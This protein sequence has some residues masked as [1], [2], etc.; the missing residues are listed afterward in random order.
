M[1]TCGF[2]KVLVLCVL[3]ALL[4]VSAA[5]QGNPTGGLQGKVTDRK[6]VV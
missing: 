5:A 4:P 3:S 2:R 1:T 6:S